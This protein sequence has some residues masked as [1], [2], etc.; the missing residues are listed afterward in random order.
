VLPV[1]GVDEMYRYD[2]KNLGEVREREHGCWFTY[3]AS[4]HAWGLQHGLPHEVDVLEGTRAAR[5]L[6]SVAYVA[7]DE[8]ED[9]SP[10]L[11]R[12]ELTKHVRY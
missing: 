8:N 6:G 7:T 2:V 11:V 12:W 9:G 4:A 1:T 10:K 5:V 3:R